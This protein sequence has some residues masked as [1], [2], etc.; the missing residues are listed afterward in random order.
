M[1]EKLM[2]LEEAVTV[3]RDGSLVGLT[4][5]TLDNA[6]MAFLRELLRR[7]TKSLRL[8]T[9]TGGGLNADLLIGA[10][11]VAEYETCSCSLGTYGPAPNFQRA[12]RSGL[13]KM[14]DST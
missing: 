8:V 7:G 3:V 6:P 11:V 2:P 5:S 4:T 1:Q 12:L 14:K 10:G 13:I 9:L